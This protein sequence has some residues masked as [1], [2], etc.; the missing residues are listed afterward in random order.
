[1]D[2]GEY[3]FGAVGVTATLLGVGL[4][5]APGAVNVGPVRAVTDT[6]RSTEPTQLMLVLGTVAGLLVAVAARPRLGEEP[7][8]ATFETTAERSDEGSNSLGPAAETAISEGGERWKELRATLAV[9]A[10]DAYADA[11]GVSRSTA[12][13]AVTRGTWTDDPL[14]AGVLAGELPVT[15]AV[16]AQVLPRRERQ[17]RAERTVTAIERLRDR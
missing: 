1:M 5:V 11:A 8:Q 14:A 13:T 9:A 15:A 12:E 4:L 16:A 3:V 6:A 10:T 2:P 7:E 17:R